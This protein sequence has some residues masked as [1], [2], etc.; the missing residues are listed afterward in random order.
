MTESSLRA[1]K[2][3]VLEVENLAVSL[4]PGGD[5]PNAVEHV[6]FTV[7]EGEVTCLIGE[8][9]SGK[10]VIASTVMGLLP[11]GLAPAEGSVKL[12][13]MDLFRRTPDEIRRLRG[14]KMAM[15]FQEPMTALNPVMTC[16]DQMDELL[17]AHVPMG[18]YERR[19][20]ILDL[21]EEVRLPD[22]PRIFRS[23]PHQLSGGQRQ[24]IV[25]AMAL[26]LKPDLLICDEPT[27]AL[28]PLGRKEILDILLSVKDHTTVVFSTHI[29]SDVERI[30]DEIALLHNGRTALKGTLEEIKS[31]RKGNGFDIE[32]YTPQDADAFAASMSGS[33]RISAVRLFF[34]G[35]DEKDMTHA[36]KILADNALC[37]QK[38]EM[39]EATLE[40]LFM[41][42]IGI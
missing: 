23:Y 13:G 33:E 14:A 8:S 21:F 39:R 28:D 41:E 26:L 29:L 37:V 10:S 31:R 20:R 27:S 15:V 30:C 36:M 7:N 16:G 2:L 1:Q 24:R 11:K 4:P 5:R 34:P 12:L 3:P 42:V 6:S 40:N 32:F 17:R 38:V 9:G 19:I 35:K 25:I 18:P 22:P